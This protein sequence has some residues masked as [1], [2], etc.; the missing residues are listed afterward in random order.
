MKIIGFQ[1]NSTASIQEP[2][3]KSQA[4]DMITQNRMCSAEIQEHWAQGI[5]AR[6]PDV[7]RQARAMR[8]DWNAKNPETPIRLNLPAIYRRVR[9]TERTPSTAHRRR[10]LP[11]GRQRYAPS[12]GSCAAIPK[13]VIV[14]TKHL[15]F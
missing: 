4:L 7:A 9:S 15:F 12:C 10:A 8:D 2:R 3:A 14:E 5:A 6:D 13:G 11:P 1:P